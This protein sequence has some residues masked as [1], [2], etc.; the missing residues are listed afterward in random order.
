MLKVQGALAN[1][2]IRLVRLVGLENHLD[3]GLLRELARLLRR[4]RLA[5]AELSERKGNLGAWHIEMASK[6]LPDLRVVRKGALAVQ[7]KHCALLA[8]A[9]LDHKVSALVAWAVRDVLVEPV[10]VAALQ[11]VRNVG[12][13]LV[14]RLLLLAVAGEGLG[15]DVD[16]LTALSL[17]RPKLLDGLDQRGRERQGLRQRHKG[18]RAPRKGSRQHGRHGSLL[19]WDALS[20][21]PGN[22]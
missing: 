8:I 4:I 13:V 14:D 17:E 2:A 5:A 11:A 20:R 9:G 12:V 1:R 10:F 16:T 22:L 15:I 19:I 21:Q 7:D 18:D 3:H 6:I